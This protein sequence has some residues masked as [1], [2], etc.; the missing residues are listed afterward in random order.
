MAGVETR[1][2]YDWF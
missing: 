2:L 1:S